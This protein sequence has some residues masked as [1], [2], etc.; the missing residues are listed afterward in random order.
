M[1]A[2]CCVALWM[3]RWGICGGFILHYVEWGIPRIRLDSSNASETK[4]H[5]NLLEA[6]SAK[7]TGE[8]GCRRLIQ[9]AEYTSKSTR[10]EMYLNL[11]PCVS[12]GGCADKTYDIGNSGVVSLHVKNKPNLR[13]PERLYFRMA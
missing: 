13:L 4:M 3:V 5:E 6:H 9:R 10:I 8:K 11:A 12:I 1:T 2:V 7:A